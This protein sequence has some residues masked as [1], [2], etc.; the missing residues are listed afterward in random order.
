MRK[1]KK[2]LI[3]NQKKKGDAIGTKKIQNICQ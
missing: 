1:W 2:N 3:L